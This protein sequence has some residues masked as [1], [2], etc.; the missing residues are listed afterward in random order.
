MCITL[1]YQKFLHLL[2]VQEVTSKKTLPVTS[3]NERSSADSLFRKGNA[4]LYPFHYEESC[5]QP[6]RVLN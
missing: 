1:S 2:G 3:L 4:W 6:Q 5:E